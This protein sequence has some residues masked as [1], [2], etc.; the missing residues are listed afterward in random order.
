MLYF[1]ALDTNGCAVQSMMSA[2]YVHPGE[3]LT[4]VGCHEN[5]H[6]ANPTPTHSPLAFQK[7]PQRPAPEPEGSFPVNYTRLVQPVLDRYCVTCHQKSPGSP[8]LSGAPSVWFKRKYIGDKHT[9]WSQSYLSLIQGDRDREGELTKG[10]AYACDSRPPGR[11]PS[12]TTPG[13][14]GARASK[15]YELLK[16]GHHGVKLPPESLR[17]LTL[18]LDCNSVFYGAYHDLDRQRAGEKV[19]PELN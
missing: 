13:N 6:R 3:T 1:Q 7:P 12:E 2:T 17:R 10:F 15:L 4:C 16:S 18:W 14:F 5:R 19:V 8:N 11:L 9:L